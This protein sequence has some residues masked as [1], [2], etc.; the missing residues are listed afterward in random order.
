AGDLL[1]GR[2]GEWILADRERLRQRC[3]DMLEQLVTSFEARA[4]HALA[5][6]YAERLLRHDPLHEQTYRL[7]MR[8]HDARGDRARA[9]RV[10]HICAATLQ[11]ELGV[12]PSPATR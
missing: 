7:L 3:L 1:A 10:Y 6:V 4:E 12:A 11:R 9:L 5:I 2:C 8:L